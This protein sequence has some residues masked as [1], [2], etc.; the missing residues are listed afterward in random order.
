ME[1]NVLIGAMTL[2]TIVILIANPI[3]I[4]I[5]L[6]VCAASD[7]NRNF[8]SGGAAIVS[9]IP[10]IKNLVN[11]ALGNKANLTPFHSQKL[12]TRY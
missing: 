4:A 5:V 7:S 12:L 3:I 10:E 6:S 8:R 1:S 9:T 2:V 11:L